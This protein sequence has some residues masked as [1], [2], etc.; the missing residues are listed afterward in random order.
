MADEQTSQS[1]QGDSSQSQQQAAAVA[2]STAQQTTAGDQSSQQQAAPQR[3]E[4]MPENLWDAKAGLK[5]DALKGEFEAKN[6][7]AAFKAAEDSRRL[8]LP[9]K[10][11]D[12]K[13]ELS[14][15]FKPP[16]GVNFTLDANDPLVPQAQQVVHDI[17]SGKLTGQEAMSKLVDLYAAG[18]VGETQFI[19]NARKAEH[20][21]LGVNG[22]A[23]VTALNTLLDARGVPSLKAM[24]VTADIIK[25]FEKFVA[26]S[27]G[28]DNFSQRHRDNEAPGKLNDDEYAKLSFSEKRAYAEKHQTAQTH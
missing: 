12:L 2:T 5:L 25:D 11:T 18:K 28:G 23:R 14:K 9:E 8:S 21:K 3:P 10:P 19:D 13:F 1:S 24:L 22:T 16:E 26:Q 6:E 20:A 4:W 7:L 15:D 17:M 27:T